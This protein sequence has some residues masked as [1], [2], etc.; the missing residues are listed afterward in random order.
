VEYE[1]ALI[2]ALI[3]AYVALAGWRPVRVLLAGVVPGTVVLAAYD[4]AAF[5][6]PWRL[7]Y[8]YVGNQYAADQATGFFGIGLPS[9]RG[10][11]DVFAWNGGLLVVS[12]VLVLAVAG[13]VLLART[14]RA[15]ALVAG[16]VTTVFVFINSGYFDAYGGLSPGPRF[17]VAALP[18]LAL[19][20]GPAFSWRPRLTVCLAALSVVPVTVLTLV[21]SNAQPLQDGVWGGLARLPFELGSSALVSSLPSSVFSKLGVGPRPSGLIAV[22]CA[23]GAFAAGVYAMPWAKIRARQP[24]GRHGGRPSL[25]SALA[26]AGGIA[27]IAAANVLAIT[28]IPYDADDPV[29]VDLHTSITA[30]SITSYLGGET[31]F[32]IS[33]TDRG[34]LGAADLRLIIRLSPGMRLVGSPG[35]T[36]GSGCSGTSRLVCN[37]GFLRSRGLQEAMV[38]FGVQFT[39]LGPQALTAIATAHPKPRTGQ[40]SFMVVVYR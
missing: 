26:I 14:Y 25:R 7:S 38:F 34:A 12:P 31:N 6:A 23:A 24:R 16:A 20:L 15:E 19:G 3:A 4:W 1:T 32:R 17:L 39:R 11:Y 5:G 30:P 27:L 37:L 10:I 18:F 33:V 21:W 2:L 29:L 9:V 13:L 35:Y 8:R 22:L 28:D 36:R 40:A